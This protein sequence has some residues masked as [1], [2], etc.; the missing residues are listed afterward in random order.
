MVCACN[1]CIW[2]S[3]CAQVEK[4][5]Q[6][7]LACEQRIGVIIVGPSGSGAFMPISCTAACWVRTSVGQWMSVE[8]RPCYLRPASHL[9]TCTPGNLP[10]SRQV[11]AVGGAGKGL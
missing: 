6:L 7:H 9:I 4:M 3:L 1:T 2:G 5:L 11:H 10:H 8:Q